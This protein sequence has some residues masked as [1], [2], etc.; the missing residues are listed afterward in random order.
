MDPAVLLRQ[1]VDDDNSDTAPISTA[2][3][4]AEY[5]ELESVCITGMTYVPS[6]SIVFC[7]KDDGSVHVYDISRQSQRQQLFVQT[8]GVPV[9]LLHF[10]VEKWILTCSDSG[11]RVVSREDIRKQKVFWETR[12]I[13]IDTTTGTRVTDIL[14]C[15]K[16]SRLLVSSDDQDTLW[17]IPESTAKSPLVQLRTTETRRWMQHTSNAG[18]LVLVTGLVAKIYHWSTLDYLGS[19]TLMD[20]KQPL[21][22]TDGLIPLH[23]SRYFATIT[24]DRTQIKSSR[25][26]I[27][28][29]DLKTLSL[30]LKL[31]SSI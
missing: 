30:D 8:P 14:A 31:V 18:H 25:R 28:V 10:D 17:E 16:Y 26:L 2:S 24:T 9:T 1:D 23:C 22:S 5:R 6:A 27:Q 21:T 13:L 19:V 29:W 20:L 4:E 12:K 3:Q 15:G 11:S 7:G